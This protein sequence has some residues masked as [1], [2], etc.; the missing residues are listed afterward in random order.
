ME[1]DDL[2]RALQ[3]HLDRMPVPYPATESGVEIRI[4]QRLFTPDDARLA[5]L[6]SAIPE[7]IGTIHRRARRMNIEALT[8]G[9]DGMADRGLI[10]K[11]PGKQGAVYCKAPMVVGFYES[12]VNRLTPELERDVRAYHEEAFGPGDVQPA[13]AADADRPGQQ[14]HPGGTR[15]GDL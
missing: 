13:H 10:N 6:L 11:L 8:A 9:L 15:R 7:P 3:Q 12:Q 4:L 1:N 2:Y 5:L 14:V